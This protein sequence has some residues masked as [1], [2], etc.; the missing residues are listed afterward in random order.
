MRT[1]F[2]IAALSLTLIGALP[3]AAYITLRSVI[4]ARHVQPINARN[5]IISFL[6]ALGL[7]FALRSVADP[8]TG[9][10]RIGS[11]VAIAASFLPAVIE[12]LTRR[13]PRLV[14]HLAAGETG[15]TYRNLQVRN[16]DL[17]VAPMFTPMVEEHMDAEILYDEP[18]VVVAGVSSTWAQRRKIRLAELVDAEWVLSPFDSLY[19]SVAAEAFRAAGLNVPRATVFSTSTPVRSALLASGRFLSI[20]QA[21]IVRFG[22]GSTNLKVLPIDLPTT[23]RPIGVITLKN[24]TLNPVAQLFIDCAREVAKGAIRRSSS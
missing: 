9:E 3:W 20:V 22:S 2:W 13:Y 8:T 15:M 16:V 5:L 24:R 21:S 12:R 7:A 6:F 17:L 19:G 11:T 18:L 10:L 23:R 4:D 1:L 14:L